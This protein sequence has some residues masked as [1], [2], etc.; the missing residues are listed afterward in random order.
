LP[1]NLRNAA[2]MKA[3]DP[4]SWP[5]WCACESVSIVRIQISG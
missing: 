1:L 2:R 5:A 4:T 3:V